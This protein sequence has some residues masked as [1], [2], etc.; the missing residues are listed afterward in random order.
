LVPK[1]SENKIHCG[2]YIPDFGKES[3]PKTYIDL[4]REAES[5]GW[6]GFFLW[7]HLIE[8]NER[9]PLFDS[10]TLLAAIAQATKRI[11]IGTTVSPLP[12][13][14]PWNVAR[15]LITLDQIS[16]GRII[17]GVGLGGEESVDYE[18]FGE[19]GDPKI[20]AKKLDES[21]EIIDGLT[22]GKPFSYPSGTFYRIM[23][24]T[25]FLPVPM[26]KPRIPIW[27]GGWWP[28][29]G[30]FK[31]AAKWDGTI[32]IKAPGELL[33]PSDLEEIIPFIE[34]ERQNKLS[35]FDVAVIGW[36][37]GKNRKANSEKVSR[38][39]SKGATW[40]LESLYTQRDSPKRM[41]ERI[42]MGPP[43]Q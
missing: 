2:L 25:V 5:A 16:N 29:K 10:F 15:R 24:K 9:V 20:L 31:R 4:A 19:S 42:K 30:P 38:F 40:W 18:R 35:N 27:V 6:D 14:K 33:A 7:D 22:S 23:G 17:L 21:L 13:S 1:R 34:S 3:T 28:N 11:R 36:T 26:Q 32:P 37:T 12:R 8:G 39:S 43:Q 41:L